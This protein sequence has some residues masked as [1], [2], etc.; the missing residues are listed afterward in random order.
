MDIKDTAGNV[1]QVLFFQ[2]GGS[3][4]VNTNT[5]QTSTHIYQLYELPLST[6]RSRMNENVKEAMDRGECFIELNACMVVVRNNVVQGTM[7]DYGVTSGAVYTTYN[8]IVEAENWSDASKNALSSYFN[9]SV[10]GL[11]YTVS[12]SGGP[13]IASVSGGGTYCYGTR[14]T[15]SA[16]PSNG[17]R[18]SDWSGNGVGYS[19]TFSFY[20]NGN[21]SWYASAKKKSTIVTFYRNS[22]VGD[23]TFRKQIF[24][25]GESGQYFAETGFLRSGYQLM[26][27]A[28]QSNATA[29]QYTVYHPVSDEWI[30]D[31]YPAVSLYAVWKANSY[32]ICF[33]GNGALSGSVASI[34]TS[35]GRTET[36][37]ENGFEKPVE[38][39]TFLGWGMSS[40][41]VLPDYKQNQAV[42]VSE[43]V[44]KT[45]IQNRDNGVITLYAIW[46]MAPVMETADLYYSLTDA[47]NGVI[48]EE[49]L[50]GRVKVTDQED[51]TI[52]YGNHEKNSLVL[53]DYAEEK[54]LNA[55]ADTAVSVTYETIDS[56]G[57]RV[58][59]TIL[60]HLVD[61]TITEGSLAV[62]KIRLIDMDYF[63]DTDGTVV[64]ESAGGLKST[65]RWLC[66]ENLKNLLWE[67]LREANMES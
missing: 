9:K 53:I 37:P 14:V 39:C 36:L 64:P 41:A 22:T 3:Y 16:S 28:H 29:A 65:S 6:V 50:S 26:G 10:N 4:L 33:D 2:L 60:V 27:W 47:Q 38:N 1:V 54:F 12:V 42:A 18:F 44:Q 51:G 55:V 45:G 31:N 57:N 35:Y 21:S 11:F 46:D 13:G 25:Y 24:T 52:S 17:Y 66:E 19:D 49:E 62:G 43:L 63:M 8:G 61:T 23:T 67:V 48:T 59:Q 40:G 32:T 15:I 58:T 30:L 20:V 56:A 34:A 5:V 7:N